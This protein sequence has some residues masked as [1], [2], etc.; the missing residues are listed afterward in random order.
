MKKFIV[1]G[2]LLLVIFSSCDNDPDSSS[3]SNNTNSGGPGKLTI[4]GLDAYNGK[5][6]LGD[7][8]GIF[9]DENMN[10]IEPIRVIAAETL[11]LE[12]FFYSGGL[13]NNGSATLNVWEYI[14]E[15]NLLIPFTG[16]GFG[17]F[18]LIVFDI[19]GI[20]TDH[21]EESEMDRAG[22]VFVT[23]INGSASGQLTQEIPEE[24]TSL[25]DDDD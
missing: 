19:S 23:F 16:S 5:Y 11:S 18:V 15:S 7:S 4:T 8:G 2:L 10:L 6:I 13:I 24:I 17:G 3:S 1:F 22:Y 9:Y 25:Y 20:I 14:E 21:L 12:P